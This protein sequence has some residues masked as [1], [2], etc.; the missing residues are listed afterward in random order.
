[1]L[2]RTET[3][4]FYVFLSITLFG[5]V[6]WGVQAA[7]KRDTFALIINGAKA[8]GGSGLQEHVVTVREKSNDASL[9]LPRILYAIVFA[10]AVIVAAL[11]IKS[12]V[13]RG[14]CVVPLLNAESA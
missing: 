14:A 8:T 3:I 5:A 13:T 1:M 12:A 10:S 6:N 4:V 7:S 11:L 2:T 9:Y